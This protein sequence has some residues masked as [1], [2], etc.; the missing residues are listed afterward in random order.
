MSKFVSPFLH[1]R[2]HP[3]LAADQA[4]T[5]CPPCFKRPSAWLRVGPPHKARL[6]TVHIHLALY[7]FVAIS[8]CRMSSLEVWAVRLFPRGRVT[9]RW[10]Q[11]LICTSAPCSRLRVR[12]RFRSLHTYCGRTR[13]TLLHSSSHPDAVGTAMLKQKC[14]LC[15]SRG[16][17]SQ[18]RT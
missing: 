6:S 4:P 8:D 1:T 10:R 13:L 12:S 7:T 5:Y 15:S 3:Y 17:N 18:G 2:A 11:H 9:P 14:R 16:T